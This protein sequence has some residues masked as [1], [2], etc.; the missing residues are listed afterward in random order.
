MTN[1]IRPSPALR[2]AESRLAGADARI[3]E[4]GAGLSAATA[5]ADAATISASWAVITAP[6]DGVITEKLV[7]PGN[8]AAPGMPLL[9]MEQTGPLRLDVRLDESRAGAFRTGQ[10]VEVRFDAGV[11]QAS[12]GGAIAG[13][14]HGPGHR[15]CP[16]G[17]SRRPRVPREDRSSRRSARAVGLVRP[18]PL[19]RPAAPCPRRAAG[20]DRPPGPT[21]LGVRAW[22]AGTRACVSSVWVIRC[23]RPAHGSGRGA[24]RPRRGRARRRPSA[25]RPAGRR[26]AARRRNRV[27]P[28]DARRGGVMSQPRGMAGRLAAA[29]IDSRLT[30]L[31]IICGHCPRRA[32]GRRAAARG[33]AA[34]HRP[35]DRRLRA[36]ARRFAGAKS[37]SASRA[38]S[39]SCCG[40][41]PASST[42]TR[43]PAR[44]SR[45]WWC[46]STWGRRKSPRSCA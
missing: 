34:D 35:D 3:A 26:P 25:S 41:C 39:R 33:G 29:F 9:R 32:R 27:G 5:G 45:W 31:I 22:T 8:M 38:R 10:A 24:G 30:P 11:V 28:A 42:S 14:G 37:S 15:D 6:F 20:R 19:Q 43:R 12:A 18:R 1:S 16:C 46:A 4:A 7:E 36:D 13:A 23:S 17:R 21:R 2:A 44:A 40:R